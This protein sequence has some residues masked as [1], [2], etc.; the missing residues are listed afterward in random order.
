[1]I[2]KTSCLKKEKLLF[3]VQ[4]KIFSKLEVEI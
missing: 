2:K 4:I 1:M 3:Y